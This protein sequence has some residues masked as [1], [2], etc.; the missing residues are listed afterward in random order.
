MDPLLRQWK[1]LQLIPRAPRHI[2]TAELK[3]KLEEVAPDYAVDLRTLQRDLVRLS[4]TFPIT[5]DDKRPAK[6][7]WMEGAAALD[8]KSVV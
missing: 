4:I 6:W 2:E 1:I 3:I 8:R 7:S 5:S